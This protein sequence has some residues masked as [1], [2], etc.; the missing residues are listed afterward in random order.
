M[1]VGQIFNQV[2]IIFLLMLLGAIIRKTNFLH[3][4]SINDLTNVTLYFLSPVVIIKAF[5]QPFSKTRFYQL[6]LLVVAVFL[7]Y[8]VSII[9]AK[10]IFHQVQD[11][12]IRRIATYG[13][14]YSNN[15]FMGVPLAQGLFGS[16][17][18][19]YA[20][21]SMVGFNVMSWTQGIGMFQT[22]E[23]HEVGRQL[24]KIILN[25]NIVAIMLGLVMFITSYR[26]PAILSDF[27]DYTSPAFTPLSMIVI[28]SNLADLNLRDV[29]LPVALWVS[30]ILRNLI[31]PI[32]GILILLIFRV[33]GVP[34]LV[35]VILNACPVAGLVVLFTLQSRDNAKPATILMSISTILSLLT[36]PLVYWLAT[37][38]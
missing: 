1:S 22:S 26:L 7:T 12:N 18:V 13:S 8:F 15:G 38:W 24:K 35:T 37:L 6:L 19:F 32:I 11:Q 14:I 34:L 4:Q 36:I 25:P 28:G 20:V 10:L 31:F 33:S 27:I 23:S 30:L 21:A 3:L 16:L 29:K 2:A 9:M 5:E 17:G